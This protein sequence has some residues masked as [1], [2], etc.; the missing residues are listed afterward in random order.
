MKIE[1]RKLSNHHTFTFE[2]DQVNFAYHDKSGSGDV[3]LAYADIPLKSSIRI[4]EN[5]W[6]RN[7]GYLWC[8]LGAIQVGYALLSNR[9]L[10]GTGFW[11]L[12]GLVCLVWSRFTKV[13]YS[14]F[15][16]DAG[17]IWVIHDA[18]THD[19]VIEEIRLRRKNQL[20]KWYGDIDLENGVDNAACKFR[21]LVEQ[22]A[23]TAEEAERR[24]S[25]VR[26]ALGPGQMPS[27]ITIN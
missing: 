10:T 18:N 5:L 13:V 16:A 11:L 9:P 27:P 7:V 26:A 8:L 14:V 24:I 21:W 23:M 20:L 22:Q 19:R 1:Q 25:Q 3:D 12:L 17:S 15:T 6:L 2:A 4:D